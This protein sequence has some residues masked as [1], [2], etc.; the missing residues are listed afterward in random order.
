MRRPFVSIIIPTYNEA[1]SIIKL[2]ATIHKVS[3]NISHEVIIVDDHSPDQTIALLSRKFGKSPWLRTFLHPGSRGLGRSIGY[4]I[5]QARGSVILGMDADGNH[6]PAI[7]PDILQALE[8]HDMVVAS[9]FVP[10][11]GMPDQ[12]RFVAS[13][14]F[15]RFIN[16]FLGFPVTDN[17]S[18]YYAI[19]KSVLSR[20]HPQ[21]IYYGY[22]DYHLRL[23][24]AAREKKL[25]IREVPVVYAPRIAGTSKSRLL[26]MF[27]SYLG[28]ALRLAFLHR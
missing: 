24:W 12:R 13:L 25:R 18:G 10:G 3:K 20:L 27:L 2:V 4:G 28:E 15:N 7:V 21:A 1:E 11:G 8:G 6:D 17:T 14:W 9:R 19:R 22:G 16:A 23:V 5:R 26:Q